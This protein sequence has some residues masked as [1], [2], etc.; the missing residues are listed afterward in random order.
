[1]AH[2]I[3]KTEDKLHMVISIDAAK[4]FKKIYSHLY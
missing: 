4:A 3:I 2:C 1:M